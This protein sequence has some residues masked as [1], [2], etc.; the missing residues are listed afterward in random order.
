MIPLIVNSKIKYIKD[1]YNLLDKQMKQGDAMIFHR[2]Q[3][4]QVEISPSA[5]SP[6]TT[7]LLKFC[8]NA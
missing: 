2:E 8:L 1:K 4:Q 3:F 6:T 7:N 5:I